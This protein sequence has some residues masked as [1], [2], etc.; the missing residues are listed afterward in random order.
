[1]ARHTL[2]KGEK[3][4]RDK[5]AFKRSDEGVYPDESQYL[6]GRSVNTRVDKD[7]PIT[8]DKIL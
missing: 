3:I 7:E 6:I 4:T 1:M 2:E 8:W 5:I